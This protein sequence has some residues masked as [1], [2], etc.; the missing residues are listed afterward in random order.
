MHKRSQR[1]IRLL[2]D[3]NEGSERLSAVV[4]ESQLGG[5]KTLIASSKAMHLSSL[6]ALIELGQTKLARFHGQI[7]VSR[8]AESMNAP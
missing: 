8:S 6:I 5:A 1:S 3:E 2:S 7:R 4:V